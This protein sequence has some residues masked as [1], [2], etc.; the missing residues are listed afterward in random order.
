MP[1]I[2]LIWNV[3]IFH[4]E[5][6][7]PPA[8]LQFMSSMY[9]RTNASK[10]NLPLYDAFIEELMCIWYIAQTASTSTRVTLSHFHIF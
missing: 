8:L 9:A 5:R 10:Y 6:Q 7:V 1:N 4:A 3:R 2:F